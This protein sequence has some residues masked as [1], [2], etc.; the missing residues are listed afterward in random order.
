MFVLAKTSQRKILLNIQ[1]KILAIQEICGNHLETP[2]EVDGK[3]DEELDI[4]EDVK[5]YKLVTFVKKSIALKRG[6]DAFLS[7]LKDLKM[8]EYEKRCFQFS[9]D[10]ESQ[11]YRKFQNSWLE[12]WDMTMLVSRKTSQM[13]YYQRAVAQERLQ[14]ISFE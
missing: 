9:E 5:E 4:S 2:N 11:L 14:K 7:C 6:C 8:K 10:R 12:T 1:N 13:T 3:E